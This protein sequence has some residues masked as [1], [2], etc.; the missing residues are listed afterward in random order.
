MQIPLLQIPADLQQP[1]ATIALV[2]AFTFS[3]HQ[4][5]ATELVSR[6]ASFHYTA[7]TRPEKKHF[8][9]YGLDLVQGAVRN[10]VDAG[11]LEPVLSKVKIVQVRTAQTSADNAHISVPADCTG[12]TAHSRAALDALLGQHAVQLGHIPRVMLAWMHAFNRVQHFDLCSPMHQRC[13]SVNAV[14]CSLPPRRPSRCCALTTWCGWKR[15]KTRWT[16]D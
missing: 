11:V 1:A 16:A 4:Q 7:Q 14:V 10:N 5:D 12:R 8:A 13:D 2:R 15:E 3:N 9:Q 6:L